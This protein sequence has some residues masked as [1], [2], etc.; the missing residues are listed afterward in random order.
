MYLRYNDIEGMTK[1]E[2]RRKFMPHIRRLPREYMDN[3]KNYL[4]ELRG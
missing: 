4:K 1:K 2:F 3:V